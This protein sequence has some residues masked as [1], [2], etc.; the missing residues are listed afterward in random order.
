M[1]R[2]ITQ[3][4][5]AMLMAACSTGYQAMQES[6]AVVP[7][8]TVHYSGVMSAEGDGYFVVMLGGMSFILATDFAPG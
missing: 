5:M 6:P 8:A 3:V 2:V 7:P 4:S 1:R